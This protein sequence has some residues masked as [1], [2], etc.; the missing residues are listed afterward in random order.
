[1]LQQVLASV[2]QLLGPRTKA[3]REWDVKRELPAAVLEELRAF[4]PKTLLG[5]KLP[6]QLGGQESV[7][8]VL[9]LLAGLTSWV[10]TTS[11]SAG[12]DLLLLLD[13]QQ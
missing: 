4:D 1:M 11:R 12:K 6:E 5:A 8:E 2:N 3:F 13:G 7:P 9:S 10:R